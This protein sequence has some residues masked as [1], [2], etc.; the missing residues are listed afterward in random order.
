[1]TEPDASIHLTT[2]LSTTIATRKKTTHTERT[3]PTK[4]STIPIKVSSSTETPESDATMPFTTKLSTTIATEK[5]TTH[6]ERTSPTKQSSVPNNV[7]PSAEMTEPDAT[8]PLTTKPSS[9][10]AREKTTSPPKTTTSA[11]DNTT[12][13]TEPSTIIHQ[14]LNSNFTQKPTEQPSQGNN[15]TPKPCE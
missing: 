12:A 4:Q 1:M 7:S 8:M 3:S 2:K 11:D 6:T 9:T 14:T 5:N 15:T 10:I 13:K